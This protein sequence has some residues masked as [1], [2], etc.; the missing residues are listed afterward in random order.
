MYLYLLGCSLELLNEDQ[1]DT[2]ILSEMAQDKE[3]IKNKT[4]SL[5]ERL[6]PRKK[7]PY[8]QNTIDQELGEEANTTHNFEQVILTF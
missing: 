8:D 5:Y 7:L 1:R 2:C 6:Q 3:S 4:E